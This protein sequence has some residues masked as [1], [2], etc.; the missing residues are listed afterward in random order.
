MQQQT[1][2]PFN[3]LR[4][5]ALVQYTIFSLPVIRNSSYTCVGSREHTHA[6]M[7]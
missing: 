2:N 5:A 1:K 7:G 3:V 6:H 4:V